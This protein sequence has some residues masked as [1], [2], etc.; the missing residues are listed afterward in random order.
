MATAA[1][2]IE[3]TGSEKRF[4]T[5]RLVCIPG[6]GSVDDVPC[7]HITAGMDGKILSVNLTLMAWTGRRRD[8]VL[9][10]L[11]IPDLLTNG[12]RIFYE[13]YLEPLLRAQG[14]V[15]EVALEL[16]REDNESLPVFANLAVRSSGN[17]NTIRVAIFNASQRRRYERGLLAARREAERIGVELALVL[18]STSDCVVVIDPNW[19]VTFAN[20]RAAALFSREVPLVGEDLRTLL[21][22]QTEG[23]FLY[24]CQQAIRSQTPRTFEA[25][26]PLLQRWFSAN[27]C[28]TAEGLSVFFHD[29]TESK[30]MEEERALALSRL[31][32]LAHHDPLTG[33]P[34]RLNLQTELS[35]YC[36]ESKPFAVLYLD[37][38]H[39]KY[40]NDTMGHLAGDE[41]LSEVAKRLRQVVKP[42]DFVARLG[43]DEFAV[44]AGCPETLDGPAL[45]GCRILDEIAKPFAL[46]GGTVGISCSMGIALSHEGSRTPDALLRESDIALYRAKAAGRRC[47]QFFEDSMDVQFQDFQALKPELDRAVRDN[48]F[49]LHYQPIVSLRTDR[50]T[51]MEALI[52]WRHPVRGLLPPSAFI[53]VAEETGLIVAIG[54]WVIQRACGDALAWPEEV[55]VAVNVSAMQF[56]TGRL[57]SDVR[58]ALARSGIAPRRLELEVTESFLLKDKAGTLSVLRQLRS[59]GVRIALDDFGTGYS[60]L[61]YLGSFP[62]DKVKI[63]QSFVAGLFAKQESLAIIRAIIG[64]GSSLG[65]VV[66]AEGVETLR[67]LNAVRA[68]GCDEGQGYYFSRPVPSDQAA[69]IFER[70]EPLRPKGLGSAPEVQLISQTA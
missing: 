4:H 33:L 11:K 7:G 50:V 2:G 31:T 56:Q 61:S 67:Q 68:E 47:C 15:N 25:Y 54:N 65:V 22:G 6:A 69:Q 38:D 59:A 60:S 43:G 8:Q 27:A 53:P 3:V 10:G 9:A 29:I 64:I 51:C 46:Q 24:E 1:D 32:F 52:R 39:F 40:I 34:N 63:D 41:L 14:S 17:T 49:E 55:R 58:A 12:S 48:E 20:C 13:T 18:E 45:L 66:T 42:E 70:F 30:L 26:V 36:A 62:F 37:L 21:P 16:Q 23:D 57:V 44:I 19:R 28:P 5:S 35:R